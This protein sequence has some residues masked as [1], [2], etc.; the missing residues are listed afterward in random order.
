MERM[1]DWGRYN[2]RSPLAL[3]SLLPSPMHPHHLPTLPPLWAGGEAV[4]GAGRLACLVNRRLGRPRA[5][6]GMGLVLALGR[7]L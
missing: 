6:W 3:G 2:A 7:S 1:R 5:G 4:T